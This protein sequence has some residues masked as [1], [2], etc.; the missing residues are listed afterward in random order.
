MPDTVWLNRTADT[1]TEQ[2]AAHRHDVA[3]NAVVEVTLTGVLTPTA[4]TA[5]TVHGAQRGL[6]TGSYAYGAHTLTLD[7]SQ[8]FFPGEVV[9]TTAVTVTSDGGLLIPHVWRFRSQ[10][11]GGSGQFSDSGLQLQARRSGA[12][13]LGDVDEDG[14][15]DIVDTSWR[16]GENSLVWRNRGDYTFGWIE[17]LY[18]TDPV[19]DVALGDLNNDGRVDIFLAGGGDNVSNANSVYLNVG[20]WDFS[21]RWQLGDAKSRGVALGDLNGDGRLDAFVANGDSPNKVWMNWSN[22]LFT[23]TAQL[24]PTELSYD[25]E[26]GDLDTDGDLDA[27][28]T[29]DGANSV[30]LN[31]GGAHFTSGQSLGTSLSRRVA[32]G[33]LDGDGDL[34]AFVAEEGPNTVWLNDGSGTFSDSAQSLGDDTSYDVALGDLDGDGDLD[35][36]VANQGPNA[37]WRNDGSGTFSAGGVVFDDINS[38]SIALGDID[39]DGDLDIFI[40]NQDPAAETNQLWINLGTADLALSKSVEPARV[41]P[42][43]MVTYTLSYANAGPDVVSQVLITDVLASELENVSWEAESA[44]VTQ[45]DSDTWSIANLAVGES[46]TLTITA[47]VTSS[48]SGTFDIVNSATITANNHDPDPTNNTATVTHTVDSEAPSAPTLVSPEAGARINDPTPTFVWNPSP[49]SDVA[50]YYLYFSGVKIDVG[51]TTSYTSPPRTDGLRSWCVSAY[52]A[53]GNEGACSG[54]RSFTIDTT[55]PPVPVLSE[56]AAGAMLSDPR[57]TLTWE[58]SSA[59]DL[60]GYRLQL[61]GVVHD[62]GNVTSYT[63]TTDLADGVHTWTVAAY[64]DLENTSA[65]AT[66]RSFTVDTTAPSPPLLHYPPDG[67]YINGTPRLTWQASPESDV[68]GYMLNFD[69]S[70]IDVGLVTHWVPDNKLDPGTYTWSVAAY[71]GAGNEGAYAPTRSFTIDTEMPTLLTYDPGAGATDVK[72]QSSLVLTFS[73]RMASDSLEYQVMP[74]PGGWTASWSTDGRI[75]TLSHNLFTYDT[76]YEVTVTGGEDAAGNPLSNAPVTWT[77]TTTD[78]ID[79]TPP[80]VLAVQPADGA[81]N[82]TSDTPLV[83]TFSEA[84]DA[85]SFAVDIHPPL[86]DESETWNT[87]GT[88]VTVTHSGFDFSTVYTVTIPEAQDLAGNPLEGTPYTWSFTTGEDL[89]YL[90]LPLVIRGGP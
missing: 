79:P 38:G 54:Y 36:V 21:R 76:A 61:D 71:D 41:A 39:N 22:D 57:P 77:F 90:Y 58:A 20:S 1:L 34:D 25:V 33:D 35:A 83:I 40:G 43:K 85:S 59:S 84:I 68:A 60:A 64:D 13:A 18:E 81:D 29:N 74:D 2:P 44:G 48:A 32:L 15:L 55:P 28:V 80:E 66:A 78:V 67:A 3:T 12:V 30:W 37:V 50:G 27:F 52:D 73:E 16:T 69:G 70:L 56:P 72:I 62:L 46:G 47:S 65:Y 75:I 14:W 10:V 4:G 6:Y 19:R 86:S 26:L 17:N 89:T 24:F 42:G 49:E 63:P 82:V 87:T 53:A 5:L 51:N 7:P 8:D 45:V 31:N 23:T 11:A 9:E 88:Q